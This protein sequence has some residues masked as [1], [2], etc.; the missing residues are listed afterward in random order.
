MKKTITVLA[1]ALLVVACGNKNNKADSPA[2][3]Q[4]YT[5]VVIDSNAENYVLAYDLGDTTPVLLFADLYLIVS[6]NYKVYNGKVA[7][8]NSDASVAVFDAQNIKSVE[9][10]SPNTYTFLGATQGSYLFYNLYQPLEDS[11]RFR[12]AGNG[13][14][15]SFDATVKVGIPDTFS[16]Q[17]PIVVLDS[18]EPLYV[19]LNRFPADADGIFV[20][21]FQEESANSYITVAQLQ[22]YNFDPNQTEFVVPGYEMGKLD[23]A[24]TAYV[25]IEL[26]KLGSIKAA[27]KS[28]A[29][30]TSTQL[31]ID[32]LT[33]K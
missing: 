20:K 24:K 5:K 16:L 13:S 14:F 27:G 28:I 23:P 18:Q 30:Y 2:P 17:N 21:I 32:N 25:E 3:V 12:I 31:K 9:M 33:V 7:F 4:T 11:V 29:A 6:N 1:L 15:P 10:Y 22:Q 19:T 8:T 26:Y